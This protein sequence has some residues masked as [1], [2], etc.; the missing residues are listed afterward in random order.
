MV[1]IGVGSFNDFE[2]KVEGFVS[3]SEVADVPLK[4]TSV[5]IT[6]TT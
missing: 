2:L 6:A 3:E 5:S 1:G 4:L